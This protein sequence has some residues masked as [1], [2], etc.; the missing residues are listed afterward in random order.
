MPKASH[1]YRSGTV[2]RKTDKPTHAG[3]LMWTANGFEES[4]YYVSVKQLWKKME[5][6]ISFWSLYF[7][8]NIN[9]L[10]RDYRTPP[11]QNECKERK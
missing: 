5:Y 7:K 8:T 2:S 4:G 11:N 3:K 10:K 6:C 9:R 1:L